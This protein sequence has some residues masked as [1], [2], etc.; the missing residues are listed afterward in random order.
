MLSDPG[1]DLCPALACAAQPRREARATENRGR[2]G[3]PAG[4]AAAPEPTVKTET[5]TLEEPVAGGDTTPVTPSSDAP[6]VPEVQT[7]VAIPY[8][9][10]NQETQIKTIL[11]E[12]GLTESDLDA[13]LRNPDNDVVISSKDGKLTQ[14]NIQQ[15][16]DNIVL[17]Q[18]DSDAP[19]QLD[20]TPPEA[21]KLKSELRGLAI[22]NGVDP[23]TLTPS[24]RAKSISKAPC[25]KSYRRDRG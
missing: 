17:K 18:A 2:D 9:N 12:N 13:I 8:R 4:A 23:K 19:P 22:A 25:P 20:T 1:F 3:G 6:P 15:L 14:K 10:K 5:P 16:K 11:S 24:G 7:E 21:P